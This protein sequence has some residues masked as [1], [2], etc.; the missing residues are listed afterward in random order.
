[1]RKVLVIA[2]REYNAAVKTR[3]FIVSLVLL[4]LMM[5][6]GILAQRA[7]EK[8][9]DTTTRRVAIID[10]CAGERL[11]GV[12]AQAVERHNQAGIYDSSGR[13]VRSKFELERI[14][15]SRFAQPSEADRVR[16]ELSQR[17]RRGEL[18]AYVEIGPDVLSPPAASTTSLGAGSSA[19]DAEE[20]ALPEHDRDKIRYSSMR[21]TYRD[22]VRLLSEALPPAV[23][24]H[25]L[26]DQGIAYEQIRPLLSPPGIVDRGLA[27]QRPDGKIV[28]ETRKSRMSAA[29][30]VPLG[31]VMLMFLVVMIGA[32]PLTANVIEEKQLRIAEVL[33]GSIRPFEL[34]LGKLLGGV[35][36]ALTL[37]AIYFG[38]AYYLAVRQGVAQYLTASTI[39]WFV[40]FTTVGTLMYGSMFVAAGAAVTNIKESQNMI[41]PVMLV[42]MLPMFALGSLVQDPG[43]GLAVA[44]SL[45]PFSAPMAMMAR[46][47]VPPGV[48]TWQLIGSAMLVVLT[49]LAVV[50]AAGRIFRVGILMQ[51]QAARLPELARWIMRG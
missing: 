40:F 15:P 45:F 13:Q 23:I 7:T 27:E 37:A 8:L 3:S 19:A 35:A 34:M 48:P 22:F 21:I 29:V 38:G 5:S 30:G 16:L 47:A 12:I 10:R 36:V 31:L 2:A 18:L 1:M 14:D 32:S 6:G 42:I 11:F 46:L 49:T 51:G 4:P 50:W 25:R 44:V 24:G 9:A 33:L 43:S 20:D 26:A 39:V 17:V 41:L 28:Y